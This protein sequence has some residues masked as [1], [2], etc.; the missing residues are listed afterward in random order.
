MRALA[1]TT[2]EPNFRRSCEELAEGWED[3]ARQEDLLG[4]LAAVAA[5]PG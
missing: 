5:E 1:E 2:F 4:E 3:L